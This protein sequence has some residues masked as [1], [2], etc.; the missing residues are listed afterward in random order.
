MRVICPLPITMPI[1]ESWMLAYIG[2][3][4]Q[5]MIDGRAFQDGDFCGQWWGWANGG[6][7]ETGGHPFRQQAPNADASSSRGEG[8]ETQTRVDGV[9]RRLRLASGLVMLAY[10]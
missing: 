5:T 4:T 3:Q 1:T 9:I 8:L 7:H 6:R 10:V 2:R